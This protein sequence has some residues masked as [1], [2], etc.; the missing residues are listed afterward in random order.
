VALGR[1]GRS[2][3]AARKVGPDGAAL[4]GRVAQIRQ[5]YTLTRQQ[6]PRVGVVALAGFLGP[7]VALLALGFA[8]GS[9]IPFGILGVLVGFLVGTALFTRRVQKA[10]YAAVAG[11]PG[12]AVAVAQRVR[13]DWKITPAVQVNR[14]QGMVHR[15]VGRPG[16]VLLAEGRGSSDLVAAERRRLR[17]AVG[18][19]PV[20]VILVG[21]AAGQTPVDKLQVT[22]M[23][24]PRVLAT[25]EVATVDRRIKA[26]AGSAP[27]AG[28]PIPKGPLPT[29]V[30]RGKGR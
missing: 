1:K 19:T 6:D 23:K 21:D 12:A 5:A 30:P 22:M 2:G 27:L 13:G 20:T 10:S 18:E 25:A 24:L 7:L 15:A 17:K 8:L 3:T 16:V 9:P 28:M 11:Q 4:P 26:L 29:R 14:D